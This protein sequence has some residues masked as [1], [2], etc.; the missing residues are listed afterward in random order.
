VPDRR[1]LLTARDGP[2]PIDRLL[3]PPPSTRSL[4]RLPE[5]AGRAIRI[6][7]TA[8]PRQ[9]V[10]VAALQM[11]SGVGAAAQ[12]LVAKD[13]LDVVLGHHG[14]LTLDAALPS[15]L[16]LGAVTVAMRLIS[17]M[18]TELSR[19]MSGRVEA[20]AVSE[21]AAAAAAATLL[22]YE[23]PGYH[24]LLQRAQMSATTRPVQMVQDLTTSLGALTSI[25]GIGGALIA[26]APPL[27]ALLAVGAVPVWL[28]QRRATRMLR[29][30][31]LAQTERDRRRSYLFL[32]LTHRDTAAD[33]RALS[34]AGFLRGRLAD[35]YRAR[36]AD[37]AVLVRR[38]I[39]ATA[40]G[41]ALSAALTLATLVLLIWLVS[42]GHLALSAAGAAAG[43]IVLLGERLHGLGTT[44]GSL[45]E[46]TLYMQ[47]FTSF[48]ARY[49][50]GKSS[51][52]DNGSGG[53]AAAESNSPL[54]DSG[55][56]TGMGDR[57]AKLPVVPL[58]PFTTLAAVDV[59]FTYPGRVE[60]AL[61]Q[62]SVE[63]GR[64]EVVA[65]VGD[66][67]SG[68]TTLAKV[69]AGLYPPESGSVYWDGADLATL[70]S[71]R[72]RR[73]VAIVLQD[74]GRF[75]MS[76]TD[77]V[78]LGDVERIDDRDAIARAARQAGADE[79][80]QA[81]PRGYDSLLGSQ[82]VGGSDLS[83]GQWQRVAL[84]RAYFRDASFVVL[85]EPTASLDARAEAGLYSQMRSLFASCSVLLISHRFASVRS[86]DRI[87]VLHAGQVVEVGTHIELMTL[88][89]R[90]AEMYDLQ[91]SAYNA[92]S[93]QPPATDDGPAPPSSVVA[94][95]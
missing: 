88:G 32:V 40:V 66:N 80:I 33:V 24:N 48:V 53:I 68:K 72:V 54:E 29:E 62:V 85:D 47:D 26:L 56:L 59:D 74:Y 36:L 18:S 92:A 41:S 8:A 89:G 82:Y 67:G 49:G 22:D 23:R 12:I 28:A 34:L 95:G 79:F 25:V 87:Y 27:A 10:A 19:L 93:Y 94:G 45:Y 61:R 43:A 75:L 31:S 39:A 14:H 90:Y 58:A 65:L 64:G 2:T 71:E 46:Q 16:L 50:P 21:V 63:V 13:V 3:A 57:S 37:L 77:N 20:H 4:R 78:A 55:H 73:S 76:A 60:P 30:F 86:A 1:S 83:V 38:R 35:V 81:L 15:V 9:L 42:R 51:G 6:T 17:T 11:L 52:S 7:W 70:D 69:L 84:A 5:Q 91:A 44:G